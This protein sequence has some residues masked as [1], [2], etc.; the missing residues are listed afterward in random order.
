MKL[1][2]A[3]VTLRRLDPIGMKS[4][5]ESASRERSPPRHPYWSLV[6]FPFSCS[7]VRR[8]M[9][10]LLLVVRTLRS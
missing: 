9:G 5:G 8:S 10:W 2:G 4:L 6:T 7:C 1:L 3:R